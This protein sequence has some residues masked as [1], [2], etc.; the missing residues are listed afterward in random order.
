MGCQVSD[1]KVYD[2]AVMEELNTDG[3]VSGGFQKADPNQLGELVAY[4]ERVAELPET[5]SYVRESLELLGVHQGGSILDV[6]CGIAHDLAELAS[7]VGQNGS[8]TFL[9]QNP[10][11]LEVAKKRAERFPEAPT[12]SFVEGNVTAL[13][14]PDN[15]FDGARVVR[16]LQHLPS[17]SMQAAVSEMTRVVKPG[18]RVV[19]YEPDWRGFTVFPSENYLIDSIRETITKSVPNPSIGRSLPVNF[20]AAGLENVQSIPKS[21][22]LTNLGHVLAVFRLED[23]CKALIAQGL[24]TADQIDNWILELRTAEQEGRF[25]AELSCLFTVGTKT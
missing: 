8:I 11:M 17:N 7:A 1:V 13:K 19:A 9:D 22:C 14:L 6:G 10:K 23:H 12:M 21:F 5:K 2:W 24:A 18:A 15:T 4:L 25:Y 20:E 3:V 16:T